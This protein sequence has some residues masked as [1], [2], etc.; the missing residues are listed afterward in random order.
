[1]TGRRS[2]ILF[3]TLGAFLGYLFY[4]LLAGAF[5]A[6]HFVK[7]GYIDHLEVAA[8]C[9]AP[10]ADPIEL[11]R[12]NGAEYPIWLIVPDVLCYGLVMFGAY[13]MWHR[14]GGPGPDPGT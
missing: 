8:I 7:W 6:I 13:W 3:A 1:M 12:G 14:V 9:T 5:V 2:H 4:C 10:I 11:I